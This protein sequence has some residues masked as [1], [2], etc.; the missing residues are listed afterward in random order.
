MHEHGSH[1]A[2]SA[3]EEQ[4]ALLAYMISHNKDHTNEIH[5]VAHEATGDAAQLLHEAIDLYNAGTE[6]LTE[7]L[8]I[9]K[10]Q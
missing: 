2:H 4:I 6:K 9:I 5:D 3:K 1:N 7:A 8:G 10:E